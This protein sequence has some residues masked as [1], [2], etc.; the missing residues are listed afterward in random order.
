MLHKHGNKF[1]VVV[2]LLIILFLTGCAPAQTTPI[3]TPVIW[4]VQYTSS[5][6]WMG[7]DLNACT[8]QLSGIALVVNKLPASALDPENAR[9]SLRWGPPASIPGAAAVIGEDQLVF[10][11]HPDNPIHSLSFEQ[12]QAI[13]SGGTR[14]WD[15]LA[16]EGSPAS[17][18]ISVWEYPQGEDV[19]QVFD[20]L[21]QR[22]GSPPGFAQVAPDPQTM[23]A[24]VSG[25]PAGIGFIPARWLTDAVQPINLNGADPALLV[26]PILALIAQPLEGAEKDWLLCLQEKIK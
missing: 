8:Q 23:I 13:Y 11:T 2:P 17:G 18:R 19:Q 20:A 16:A 21:V 25:D 12:V 1:T 5:L 9:F 7:V 4:Q 6:G 14:S 22:Q 26:Q 24:A 3:P 15:N 10:I